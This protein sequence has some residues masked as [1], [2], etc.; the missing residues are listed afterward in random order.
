MT[1]KNVVM[2]KS[3]LLV[4][5]PVVLASLFASS[6]T[7]VASPSQATVWLDPMYS[8]K[9]IGDDVY[10]NIRISNVAN[11]YYWDI[12]LFYE[13]HSLNAL[14]ITEGPFLESFAGTS[15]T[16]FTVHQIDDAYNSTHGFVR[17]SCSMINMPQYGQASGDGVLATVKFKG[18]DSRGSHLTLTYPGSLY[19]VVLTH[20][21]GIPLPCTMTGADVLIVGPDSVPLD[22]NVDAG[23]F[24]FPGEQ[25]ECFVTT[26]YR[27]LWVTATKVNAVLNNPQ[28][29]TTTLTP[30]LVS[31]GLYKLAFSMPST[32]T[33]GTWVVVI[34]AFYISDAIQAYGTAFKTCMLSSALNSKLVYIEDTV[35]ILETNLGLIQTDISSLQLQVTSI[36]GNTATIQT[37]LGTIQGT[38]T[39]ING[40]VATIRTDV[41]TVKADISTIKTN[42]TPQAVDWTTIGLY[43]SLAL[44]VSIAIVLVVLYLYLRARFRSGEVSS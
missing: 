18:S 17:V 36:Q 11:L 32:A 37:T 2:R 3:I 38:I 34:E 21:N 14:E 5:I 42:T 16:S 27:G 24:Y 26:T 44:L 33:S 10:V 19:P 29:Q 8:N 35:A 4:L 15:G 31:A 13:T 40:N 6:R 43:I 39:S 23:S 12:K 25:V 1:R 30:Q 9:M 41:G 28:G 7:V 20:M 22:I